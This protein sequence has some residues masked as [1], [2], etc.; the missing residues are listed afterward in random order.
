MKKT[1]HSPP[2]APTYSIGELSRRT[3]LSVLRIRAWETR[4]GVP[5]S[6]RAD[7]GHRRY[8]TEEALR[9]ELLAQAVRAGG[10]IGELCE[11]DLE[12]L[13]RRQP[14]ARHPADAP[15]DRWID[16]VRNAQEQALHDDMARIW[17][18]RGWREFVDRHAIPFLARI[19]QSW[20]T[21]SLSVAQEHFA[22][23]I[24]HHFIEERWRLRNSPNTGRPLILAML[25]GD[26]HSFG[27]HLCALAA[28]HAGRRV[29]WLG[30][31]SPAA[32]VLS[33]VGSWEASGLCLSL[34]VT[35]DWN[36]AKPF[37]VRL[38]RELDPDLPFFAG[39]AGL[40]GRIKGIHSF[41]SIGE[42]HDHLASSL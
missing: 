10:R 32:T 17:E 20:E 35:T 14:G 34:S 1:T 4:H 40:R 5:R 2:P 13:A 27:L 19:G 25:P 42:F 23:G 6:L 39:G 7:S 28:A 9:L 41:Q 36:E 30:P 38:R 29:L 21:G 8:A 3:G 22:S 12:A 37:L 31:H 15:A 18:R 11:L 33:A 16:W 24:L 26:D